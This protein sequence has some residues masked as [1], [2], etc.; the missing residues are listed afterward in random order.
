[1]EMTRLL[2]RLE[3]ALAGGFLQG[4]AGGVRT[5][6]EQENMELMEGML[7]RIRSEAGMTYPT[8][9]YKSSATG[10][11]EPYEPQFDAKVLFINNKAFELATA[12]PWS[13]DLIEKFT[14]Y[15]TKR[16]VVVDGVNNLRGMPHFES[17][18]YG[19]AATYANTLEEFLNKPIY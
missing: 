6:E 17:S 9:F 13:A 10:S 12:E 7:I 5:P 19:L 18:K 11:S 1:M 14:V 2:S 16:L 15:A 8:A 3:S 4:A